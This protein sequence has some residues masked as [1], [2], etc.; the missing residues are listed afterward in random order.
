MA[1][2]DRCRK[3]MGYFNGPGWGDWY[4]E[5]CVK[6]NEDEQKERLAHCADGQLHDFEIQF[7]WE[8]GSGGSKIHYKLVRCKRPLCKLDERI[9]I[10]RRKYE[11]NNS[12]T[13]IKRG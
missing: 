8:S 2:C 10:R 1:R 3:D 13:S 6:K 5:D 9:Y 12:R 7:D 4:C 11:Q